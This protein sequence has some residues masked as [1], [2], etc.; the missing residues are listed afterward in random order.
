MGSRSRLVRLKVYQRTDYSCAH[1]GF[2]FDVPEGYDGRR[3]LWDPTYV[4][5][6]GR[7]RLRFLEIDHIW[8]R[9]LGGDDGTNHDNLQALCTQ[10]N[11]RKWCKV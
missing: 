11:C 3:S 2:R 7:P 10:C 8:P 1:C 4:D 6:K 9:H 5:S